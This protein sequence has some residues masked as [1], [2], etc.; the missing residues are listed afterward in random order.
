[1]CGPRAPGIRIIII[2]TAYRKSRLT[3]MNHCGGQQ[4]ACNIIEFS[5]NDGID[6]ST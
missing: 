6:D 5:A 2:I 3:M 1:M 4:D